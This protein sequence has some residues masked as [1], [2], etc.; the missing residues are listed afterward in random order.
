MSH[1][2]RG[3]EGELPPKPKTES[4]TCCVKVEIPDCSPKLTELSSES[5][6][7]TCS[8][9]CVDNY[10]AGRLY[11]PSTGAITVGIVGALCTSEGHA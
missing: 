3:R 2:K 8:Q 1:R 10:Y 5:A 4:K 9:P 6:V 7:Y 11:L